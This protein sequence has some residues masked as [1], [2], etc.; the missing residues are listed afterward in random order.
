MREEATQ[1]VQRPGPAIQVNY[2]N[3][4]KANTSFATDE[5][6]YKQ[7]LNVNQHDE[8]ALKGAEKAQLL[9]ALKQTNIKFD[10]DER[11]AAL[12]REHG[13]Q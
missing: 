9:E 11:G 3:K 7:E 10:L 12:F 13:R 8:A 4:Y 2:D 6:R 5:G 1:I